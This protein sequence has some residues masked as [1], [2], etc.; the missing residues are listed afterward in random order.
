L[1]RYVERLNRLDAG[2]TERGF[3]PSD[4]GAPIFLDNGKIRRF[5]PN[6][7]QAAVPVQAETRCRPLGVIRQR[8]NVRVRV[9]LARRWEYDDGRVEERVE[10]ENLDFTVRNGRWVIAG[11]EREMPEKNGTDKSRQEPPES[12]P[13]PY[14]NRLLLAP[15]EGIGDR[16][17]ARTKRVIV[18]DSRNVRGGAQADRHAG[19]AFPGLRDDRGE[20][21]VDRPGSHV[22]RAIRYDR[23]AAV[24]Y[25]DA[26]WNGA[27]PKYHHFAVDC[28]NYVSQCLFAGGLP[29]DYT[30]R[31]DSGWWYE[32]YA[33]STER[34]SFSWAVANSL[35][36]YLLYS[37]NPRRGTEKTDPRELEPGDVIFYD[38]DGDGRWQ[39][40]VIVTGHDREGWPLVNAHTNNSRRRSWEYRDSLAWS[41][42]TRYSFIHIPD[43]L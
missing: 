36:A 33:G 34:W 43:E 27:N 19:S 12:G 42:R 14:I 38:W 6:R 4:D 29:M 24:A 25:A 8:G 11:V 21:C 13:A 17:T 7:L 2:E 30:G 28:T 3:V 37:S 1:R 15:R 9:R 26:W 10:H 18:R 16:V 32:G 5:A 39:H 40:S 22:P 31:R 20:P 35:R 23:R 41:D